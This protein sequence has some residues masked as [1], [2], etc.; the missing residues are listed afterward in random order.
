[1]LLSAVIR[2]ALGVLMLTAVQA[3]TAQQQ[4]YKYFRTGASVDPRR[5]RLPASH[6]WA[7]ARIWMLHSGG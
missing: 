3:R 1:M 2:V 4:S 6:L 5:K 7:A